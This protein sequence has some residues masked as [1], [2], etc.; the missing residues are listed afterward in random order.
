M[1]R[2]CYLLLLFFTFS[3]HAQKVEIE[4]NNT[5]INSE[6]AEFGVSYLNNNTI[7]FASS[8]KTDNDKTFTTTRRRQNKQLHLELY[9]GDILENGDVIQRSK[10]SKKENNPVL[11]SDISFSPDRKTV[12]FT[13]NNFY[14]TQTRKDS[15]K[16]KT[17]QIVKANINE[18]L[19]ITDIQL[20]PFNSKEYSV[21]NPEVSKD[22]KQ[23]FFVSNMP[24]NYGGNDI[25]VVDI[26]GN[27]TYSE[28]KNLG[29][30]INTKES[31][32]FPFVDAN[33]NLY[34]ST[35]GHKGMGQLDIYKSEFINGTYTTPVPLKQPFNSKYD[36]FGYV[37][38]PA[39]TAGYITSNRKES[40]G[41]V[42]IFSWKIKE[43]DCFSEM[44]I[45]AI[46]ETSQ[47]AIKDIKISV[48]ENANELKNTISPYNTTKSIVLKCNT[49]YKILIEKEGFQH[50]EIIFKT[51]AIEE[52]VSKNIVLTP[53]QCTQ[54]I[55]G[56]VL[57]N[58]TKE[59]ISNAKVSLFL[60][61]E[62]IS[63]KFTE[64]SQEFQFNAKC[65]A[66]YKITVEKEQFEVAELNLATDNTLN[67][68]NPLTIEL[69]PIECAQSITGIVL[70]KDTK[71]PLSNAKVSLFLNNELISTKF[72]ENAQEFQ[73]NAKCN[74]NY[75]ITVEKEQFEVTEVNLATDNTLNKTNP[76][77]IE[78]TAIECI[79]SITGIVLNKDTKEP[80][81]NAK[82]SLFLNNELISTK[83]TEN[84]QE[85]QFNAKCNAN[86]KITVEKEQFEVAEV[87][88]A[89]DNTLNKTNP[90]TIELTPIECIQSI[91]GIVLN[92]DTKEPL[93]NA[94]VSLF[95]NNKL[96]ESIITTNEKG[97]S[98]NI[99]CNTNAKI[100][101]S[102]SGFSP[103]QFPIV[104][105]STNK[106]QIIKDVELTSIIEFS[107]VNNLKS[108][109]T[110]PI[111]FDLDSDE[112]TTKAAIE[113]NKVVGVLKS[114]PT[115]KI[116]VQS[117]T[118]SRAPDAYNLTLSE[119]R[120]SSS[121]EYII[122][123]G[124]DPNRI[125]M[126]GYGETKLLNK[127]A[128]G[129]TCTNAEHELNRRTEFVIINE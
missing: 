1:K 115:L 20:L 48:F 81:S 88:L 107:S 16:W 57:N 11:E 124:I 33:K 47:L 61:N 65:N 87:N 129:V 105:T 118:D 79:Q 108:I 13:W 50:K 126:K 117:H 21:R 30:T 98:F 119:K 46:N 15:A 27:N 100:T 63:T 90:L 23:L 22:G 72:T 37:E 31:E 77:T 103:T 70:N 59:P 71:E 53:I 24:G 17:L 64:G 128:N 67:K 121:A 62:L 58:E 74:A 4:L 111:Y 18:Q 29:P 52:T 32:F 114:Y 7:L 106:Q 8:K 55:T 6:Y 25:Y 127:C 38:N 101:V 26:L 99:N 75:K 92:K 49:S 9:L 112:I 96:I 89:T 91:T 109:K 40:K 19:D 125:M 42:D 123:Q 82:V 102:K 94:K 110:N 122:S 76:L 69:T 97:Y 14:N 35:S 56:I 95:L 104:T 43:K 28:P 36:D 93:S 60:N 54:S 83:F 85:F 86:Y 34:F 113:L 120:A 45:T 66:N 41:G 2:Y 73:F 68:T 10:F 39:G 5:S 78:L 84:A 44:V 3:I 116:E 80:L 12:Y 51:A